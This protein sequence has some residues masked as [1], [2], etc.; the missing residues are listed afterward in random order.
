MGYSDNHI[1]ELLSV[2]DLFTSFNKF[3]DTLQVE[4]D[5]PAI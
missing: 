3:L 4:I 1:V 5:F 2:V